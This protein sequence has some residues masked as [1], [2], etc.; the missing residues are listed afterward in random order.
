MSG[1]KQ[2][3]TRK[4]YI[5]IQKIANNFY[6]WNFATERL[7]NEVVYGATLYNYQLLS[8][9]NRN[10]S[11]RLGLI[12]DQLMS[13]PTTYQLS[14]LPLNDDSI[15]S[16]FCFLALIYKNKRAYSRI[17][18]LFGGKSVIN[19]QVLSLFFETKGGSPPSSLRRTV[20]TRHPPKG[21]VYIISPPIWF[22]CTLAATCFSCYMCH[23][24]MNL[25]NE[26]VLQSE[27]INVLKNTAEIA[28]YCQFDEMKLNPSVELSTLK[29]INKV[30]KLLPAAGGIFD[31]NMLIH[32]LKMKQCVE[33]FDMYPEAEKMFTLY[34]D[35]STKKIRQDQLAIVH[36]PKTKMP[37][38][39]ASSVQKM[40]L[41]LTSDYH[42]LVDTTL[43]KTINKQQNIHEILLYFKKIKTLSKDEFFSKF[44]VPDEVDNSVTI[45][46]IKRVFGFFTGSMSAIDIFTYMY[47][48]INPA[49]EIYNAY[50]TKVD[51]MIFNLEQQIA[52]G[53]RMT[54]VLVRDISAA[55]RYVFGAFRLCVIMYGVIGLF[56][57]SC[58]GL[59]TWL[60]Q[61]RLS[62]QSNRLETTEQLQIE[63][64]K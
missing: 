56:V 15:A 11:P 6:Q 38:P 26:R 27:G 50:Q 3:L 48:G 54:N 30:G 12:S 1:K 58:F 21:T 55:F 18:D 39:S 14:S 57:H 53:K 24:Y 7:G 40:Q 5:P 34:D 41:T 32:L 19:D 60:K 42:T 23:N 51:E 64:E 25:F 4:T 43:Q 28:R 16:T 47:A 61:R 59:R 44:N 45:N 37:T 62:S 31:S 10:G 52:K 13:N 9:I 49:T 2:R 29:I 63:N 8:E 20:S 33:N 36:I 17:Q 35:D 46:D 22:A